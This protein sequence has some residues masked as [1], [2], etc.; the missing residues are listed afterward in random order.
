MSRLVEDKFSWGKDTIS[1]R[2]QIQLD[3]IKQR[4]RRGREA[5]E[6]ESGRQQYQSRADAPATV[7]RKK[8]NWRIARR[9][10]VALRLHKSSARC[11][12]C[13]FLLMLRMLKRKH[14]Q[15]AHRQSHTRLNWNEMSHRASEIRVK[16]QSTCQRVRPPSAETSRRGSQA[17]HFR[18]PSQKRAKHATTHKTTAKH[19][20]WSH[21]DH[22]F[23]I[24]L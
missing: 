12:L 4:G 21:L 19:F 13:C 5:A 7:M 1:L 16:C 8:R 14:Q 18:S 22:K 10:N 9:E 23:L 17:F 15:R 24:C 20:A 2:I 6:C 3:A 11:S